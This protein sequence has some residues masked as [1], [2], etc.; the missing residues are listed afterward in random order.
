MT[1]A[2]WEAICLASYN[3]DFN[4]MQEEAMSR[5]REMQKRSRTAVN[6]PRPQPQPQPVPKPSPPPSPPP[7]PP[8]INNAQ[9]PQPQNSAPKPDIFKNILGD[10]KIDSEKALI[11]LMLFVLYKNKADMKLLLAL[12]YLLI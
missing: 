3:D 5:L 6:Q 11:L 7:P 2:Y 9:R 4:R 12:G 1:A 8:Q 10:I